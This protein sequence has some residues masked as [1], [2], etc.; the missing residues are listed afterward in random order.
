MTSYDL[1]ALRLDLQKRLDGLKPQVDRNRLGQFATPTE[2]AAEIAAVT[3]PLMAGRASIR[4]LDPA[5]G[6]GAFYSA[7]LRSYSPSD[8]AWAKGYEV[9]PHYGLPALSLWQDTH[10]KLEIADFTQL[11]PPTTDRDR[12]NLII[13]NPPYV[14]HHH[15]PVGDKVRLRGKVAELTS[16]RLNGLAGLYCYFLCLAHAWLADNGIGV[17]LIPSEFMDVKYGREVK[18][19]LL[20]K[21]TLLRLHLFDPHEVQ[22]DDALVSSAVVWFTKA[23]PPSQHAVDATYGGSLTNPRV[24][25]R[26]A[27]THLQEDTKWS[28]L[29]KGQEKVARGESNL[30]L[31][32]LFLIKR[33][34]ATGSN[35]FF[36]LKQSEAG[37]LELPSH[38]LTPILPSPR[39][40][41]VEE[42]EADKLGD[43]LLATRLYLLTCDEPEATVQRKYPA[44]WAYLQTGIARGLNE[45]YLC[46]RRSPW[47]A[48]EK[49][50][51]APLLCTY[52]GRL[53]T[54]NSRPFRFILNHSRA[55][56]PNVYLLMYPK[57]LLLDLMQ[58]QPDLLR[59]LW[60][61]LN[62]LPVEAILG[63]GRVYG[64]GL[65]K[66][67]PN[68]LGNLPA[69]VVLPA[70]SQ[71]IPLVPRQ[72]TLLPS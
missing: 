35:S 59:K 36:V 3:R 2:L 13:C 11:S 68:E 1:E 49:R 41:D 39:F 46:S 19:Y 53:R 34:I 6:T 21:V 42:V 60:L 28:G 69:D 9:D 17:W 12:P 26:L 56:A 29:F 43:P 51:P 8:I 25:Q 50:P 24:V 18:R 33:G 22:F 63:E 71:P 48:Q 55:T 38:L 15:I 30:K 72:L 10:L 57:P 20:E 47:Y 65:Y 70:L 31:S 4:F 14:R 66:L 23:T 54:K 64:G 58:Q 37:R 52:M 27:T 40:L 62:A 67:E 16:I 44:L 7:L 61:A 32:D 45:G 5:F